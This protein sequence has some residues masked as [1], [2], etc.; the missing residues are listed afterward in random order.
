MSGLWFP[1]V[2]TGPTVT[3]VSPYICGFPMALQRVLCRGTGGVDSWVPAIIHM[4]TDRAWVLQGVHLL[5]HVDHNF[6]EVV[7]LRRVVPAKRRRESQDRKTCPN[8][9][10][11]P[12]GSWRAPHRSNGSIGPSNHAS[13]CAGSAS[14]RPPPGALAGSVGRAAPQRDIPRAIQVSPRPWCWTHVLD[15]VP[16]SW[17]S[18]TISDELDILTAILIWTADAVLM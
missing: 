9:G 11:A 16:R 13:A 8:I 3:D 7:V 4:K 10:T 15:L 17:C 18:F 1:C 12:R 14:W 6:P 2:P 5:S